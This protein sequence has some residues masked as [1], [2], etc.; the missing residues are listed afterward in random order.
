MLPTLDDPAGWN[1]RCRLAVRRDPQVQQFFESDDLQLFFALIEKSLVCKLVHKP[2]C[3]HNGDI[4]S[5]GKL[6]RIPNWLSG[7]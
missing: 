6:R 3:A 1:L 4:C 7:H 5:L 2:R